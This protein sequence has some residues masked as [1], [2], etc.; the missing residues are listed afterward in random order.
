M[1]VSIA[2]LAVFINL[3]A[4]QCQYFYDENVG[5]PIGIERCSYIVEKTGKKRIQ[6][7]FE[8]VCTSE[9]TAKKLTYWGTY[10]CSGNSTVKYYNSNN[11]TFACNSDYRNC[12][13]LFGGQTPCGCSAG[14]DDCDYSIEISLVDQTCV[15]LS[16][17]S[18]VEYKSYSWDITCGS[19]SKANAILNEY[20]D[21]SCG[22]GGVSYTYYAGCH[23]NDAYKDIFIGTNSSEMDVIVCPGN[24]ASFSFAL[25]A[26]LVV[27]AL[28]L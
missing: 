22:S 6:Y 18:N 19:I 21:N 20:T 16:S 12:G 2:F 9:S 4:S 17:D 11:A 28:A 5:Y 24:M 27:A 14:N 25:I 7:S 10:S 15:E 26:A 13:K 1:L 8:Y 23:T 3:V